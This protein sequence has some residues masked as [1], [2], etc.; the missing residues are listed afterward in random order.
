L[1]MLELFVHAGFQIEHPA[2]PP[3]G[4]A[5]CLSC[6]ACC[7]QDGVT[8]TG[9]HRAMPF[10]PHHAA[11]AAGH[12]AVLEWLEAHHTSKLGGARRLLFDAR[13]ALAFDS[14]EAAAEGAP[15]TSLHADGGRWDAEAAVGAAP[16]EAAAFPCEIHT[17]SG[18]DVLDNPKGFYKRFVAEAQP[19]MIRNLLG[20]D[21]RLA[22]TAA[23]LRRSSLL[24]ALGDTVWEI[25]SIP[26]EGRYKETAPEPMRLRDFVATHIDACRSSSDASKNATHAARA[27]LQYVFAERFWRANGQLTSVANEPFAALPGWAQMGKLTLAKSAQ[28]YL[29][30]PTSGSPMHFHQA[31]Y[32]VLAFGRKRWYLQPPAHSVFS[33]RPAH[34]W[35]EYRLPKVIADGTAL[36]QC[37]QRAGDVLV[38]PDLWG[39][40]T[41][42]VET[43]VGIAQ[44]FAWS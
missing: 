13:E 14:S 10:S 21:P 3:G 22:P 44:E 25:G 42:N 39:H 43:S 24:E 30:G 1:P 20:I 27:C 16:A 12:R 17:V 34:E 33:M 35:L 7:L 37:E 2:T 31:A 4:F 41:W 32:N 40:L 26:Y 28:F 15:S 29:G 6:P 5:R 11:A 9:N 23:A 19:V 8:P 38:L 18:E 36:Y